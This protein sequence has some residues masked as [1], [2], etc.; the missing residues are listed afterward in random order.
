MIKRKALR[1]AKEGSPRQSSPDEVHS[2]KPAWFAHGP[3]RQ[4][5]SRDPLLGTD[6]FML[7][8][9]QHISIWFHTDCQFQF[10][11]NTCAFV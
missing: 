5:K 1:E 7:G 6:M 3:A 10:I 4:I 2:V 11:W 8:A 9:A